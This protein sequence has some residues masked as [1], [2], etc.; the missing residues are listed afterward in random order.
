[1][2]MKVSRSQLI[3]NILDF[4]VVIHACHS[5]TKFANDR[6]VYATDL[7]VAMGWI[8]ELKNGTDIEKVTAAI[9]SPDTSKQ[10]SDYWRQGDWADKEHEGL[11]Q[12]R[13][14]L[15]AILL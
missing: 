6:P 3:E 4:M 2:T 14:G 10:F 9:L 8:V 11:K 7:I 13:I 12:L 15:S 1:M 5:A